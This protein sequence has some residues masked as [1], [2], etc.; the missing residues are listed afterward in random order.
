MR[1]PDF[2]L[3]GSGVLAMLLGGG[4]NL[5]LLPVAVVDSLTNQVLAK[6][7]GSD[8][9]A[10]TERTLDASLYT[11]RKVYLRVTDNSTGGWGHV[12]LDYVRIPQVN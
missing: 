8:S 7:S 11:G 10:L 12:N 4:N 6:I 3:G 9:E 1:T 2:T 5:E